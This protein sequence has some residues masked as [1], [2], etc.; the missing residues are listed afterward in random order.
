MDASNHSCSPAKAGNRAEAPGGKVTIRGAAKE[1][2][3]RLIH[4]VV[5]KDVRVADGR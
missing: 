3:A 5:T 2:A 1:Y 4:H